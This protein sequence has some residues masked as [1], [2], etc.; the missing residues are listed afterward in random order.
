MAGNTTTTLYPLSRR[1]F[2]A[3]GMLGVVAALGGCG[4]SQTTLAQQ[5]A[6]QRPRSRTANP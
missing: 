5:H 2:L 3:L 4:S 6:Q 1:E